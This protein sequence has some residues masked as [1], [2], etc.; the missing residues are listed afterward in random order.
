MRTNA[1][2][3][4]ILAALA[5]LTGCSKRYRVNDEALAVESAWPYHRGG[6][7]SVGALPDG[8]FDGKLDIVW[9]DHTNTKPVGPLTIYHRHLVYPDA[10]NKI[11]FINTITGDFKGRIKPKG[12]PQTGLVVSGN[13]AF[14]AVG[15]RPDRLK[16]FDL[17]SGKELWTRRFNDASSGAIVVDNKLIIGSSKGVLLALETETGEV[18]WHFTTESMLT[19]PASFGDDKIIQPGDDGV[20]YALSPG[21]GS[22]IFRTPLD[23][24]VVSPAAVADKIYVGDITGSVYALDLSNGAV[25]WRTQLKGPIWTSPAVAHG[26]IFVG[27]SAGELVAL[28]AATGSILWK[29]NTVDVVRA[30]PVIAGKYVVVGTMTGKLFSLDMA[31]GNLVSQ[32]ELDGPIFTAPVTDGQRVY[33]ATD[34]GYITCFGKPD[35]SSENTQSDQ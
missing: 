24:E 31:T 27:H 17:H 22:E 6:L 9:E 21:D 34:K 3:L 7:S 19:V 12:T 13:L 14:F 8:V 26:K 33:V 10:R 5:L 29:Y 20:L 15:P 25:V 2:L 4:V 1:R 16:C 35:P 30:S 28:D 23:G 18:A 32:R 11:R